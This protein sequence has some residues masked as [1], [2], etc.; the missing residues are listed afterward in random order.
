M[1]SILSVMLCTG[2]FWSTVRLFVAVWPPPE[3]VDLLAALPRPA[4]DGLRWTTP[5]QWH[6]T[7]RFLGTVSLDAVS[8]DVGALSYPPPPTAV[9]RPEAVRLGRDVLALPV[10]GLDDL[11]RVVDPTPA[12]PFRGHLTLARSRRG[13]LP[14]G[15]R[16]LS[17][18]SWVVG[19]VTLV[20]SRLL[21][22]GA[23]YT[24]VER[25][26]LRPLG[27]GA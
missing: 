3:V 9:L 2:A 5:D 11:A 4:V 6:V 25:F 19:E 15:V 18:A 20:S 14:K 10:D 1:G 7:L 21:P 24:V 26:R 22:T 13:S 23:E 8:L 17:G 27:Q 12:R 16:L